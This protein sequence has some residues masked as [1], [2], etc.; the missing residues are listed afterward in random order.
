ML[1]LVELV[2][3]PLLVILPAG[4]YE[5]WGCCLGEVVGVPGGA[6]VR[7][8][9]AWLNG[10]GLTCRHAQEPAVP[11]DALVHTGGIIGICPGLGGTSVVGNTTGVIDRGTRQAG[12]ENLHHLEREGKLLRAAGPVTHFHDSEASGCCQLAG[13][14]LVLGW[15]AGQD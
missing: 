12:D 4:C 1:F 15:D 5:F 13:F 8:G 14:T 7:G 11:G 3:Q 6:G 10:S 2:S 9:V